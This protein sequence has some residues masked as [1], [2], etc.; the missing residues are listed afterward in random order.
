VRPPAL[1]SVLGVAVGEFAALYRGPPALPILS[2][3][4]AYT[5]DF[6][7]GDVAV[8]APIAPGLGAEIDFEL[9]KA[10]MIGDLS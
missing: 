1:A 2:A 4:L 6:L 9:I 10:K 3:T 5:I 7:R 8:K